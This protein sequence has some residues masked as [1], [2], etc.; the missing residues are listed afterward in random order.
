MVSRRRR[1][2]FLRDSVKMACV[3]DD[4]ASGLPSNSYRFAAHA[5]V[6][7]Q[8]RRR[9]IRDPRVLDAMAALP[10]HQFVPGVDP[11]AAYGDRALPTR[12]GQ[13]ISQPYVTA[14]MT[15]WLQAGGPLRVLEVGTGSGYQTALLVML[16]M[17]VVTVEHHEGLSVA[18]QARL[19]ELN[20]AKHVR[21]V[22]GDGSLGFSPAAPFD[23]ILVTASV[24]HPPTALCAQ[25]A[26][27]GA[28]ILPL[29]DRS[30]QRL[31]RMTLTGQ[32][33]RRETGLSCRFVPLVGADAWPGR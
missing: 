10:R 22:I 13:T 15:Q 27:G 30:E 23:R 24:P 6:E 7:D 28:M 9:D 29:G 5:M 31:T 8:L 14:W 25:L 26:P 3:D 2:R 19:A 4:P 16:G 12:D 21:F 18:A 17:D 1:S 32:Q 11:V 20:L 33:W